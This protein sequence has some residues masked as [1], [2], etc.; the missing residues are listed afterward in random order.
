MASPQGLKNRWHLQPAPTLYARP[1][2]TPPIS[3]PITAS[4]MWGL[5][6]LLLYLT[7]PW[8]TSP[9]KA[10]AAGELPCHTRWH[11]AIGHCHLQAPQRFGA[12]G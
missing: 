8:S 6:Y 9:W 4:V 1:P 2:H 3:H 7:S 10:A 11:T 12:T 5:A